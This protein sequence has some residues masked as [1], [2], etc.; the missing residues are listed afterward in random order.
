MYI[1]CTENIHPEPVK[2]VRS[3]SATSKAN[4]EVPLFNNE[5]SPSTEF[6]SVSSGRNFVLLSLLS[7]APQSFVSMTIKELITKRTTLK[8]LESEDSSFILELLNSD[9]WINFI[10]DRN[11]KNEE[12]ALGYIEKINGNSAVSYWVV[13][14]NEGSDR[15]G[16]ITVIKKDKLDFYDIGFAFLPQFENN[17]YAFEASEAVMKFIIEETDLKTILAT[18]IPENKSSIRLIEKLGLSYHKS[19]SDNDNKLSVYKI[20][21]RNHSKS[22]L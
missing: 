21:L 4:K 3:I 2:E 16:I 6:T 13:H 8:K 20:E 15:L 9:G 5:K 17:G 10:G 11:I 7:F 1:R 19:V 18:T 22:C 12:D 14:L